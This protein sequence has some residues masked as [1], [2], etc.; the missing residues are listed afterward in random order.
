MLLLQRLFG[1]NRTLAILEPALTIWFDL[2][3]IGSSHGANFICAGFLPI[4]K[5]YMPHQIHQVG[6]TFPIMD[7]EVRSRRI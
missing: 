6:G 4:F 7:R 2:F 1:N 5:H 3:N